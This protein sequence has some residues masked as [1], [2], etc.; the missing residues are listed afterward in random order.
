MMRRG[1]ETM[2]ESGVFSSAAICSSL[3]F[4]A[5]EIEELASLDRGILAGNEEAF[6]VSLR[7]AGMSATDLETGNVVRFPSH[8][9]R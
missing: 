8:K 2:L 1:F 3:P 4:P 6:S 5:S 7:N 9:G